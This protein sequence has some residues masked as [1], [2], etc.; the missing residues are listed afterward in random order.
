MDPNANLREQLD[1]ARSIIEAIDETPDD[2]ELS[3]EEFASHDEDIADRNEDIAN[4][5][6][7]LAERVIALDEWRRK[8]GFDPYTPTPAGE[9]H[10][11]DDPNYGEEVVVQV[12]SGRT[13]HTGAGEAGD[14]T[15]TG[16]YVRVLD[17]EGSEVAYWTFDEWRDDPQVVMGA[18]VGCL[19][20]LADDAR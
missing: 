12:V 7:Q 18:I 16:E 9:T 8:G 11:V 1:L 3:P 5:A 14:S 19:L 10:I 6:N 20:G 17:T 13:L 2:S 15:V 4:W